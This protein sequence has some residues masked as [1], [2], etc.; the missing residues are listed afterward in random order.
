MAES[1]AGH[2]HCGDG[3]AAITGGHHAELPSMMARCIDQCGAG[4]R[5]GFDVNS[6]EGA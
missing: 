4:Q 3:H 5:R 1:M 2:R 6:S